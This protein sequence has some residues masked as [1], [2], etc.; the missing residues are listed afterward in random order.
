MQNLD[1]KLIAWF[2]RSELQSKN[3]GPNLFWHAASSTNPF[4]KLRV[5]AW[6]LEVLFATVLGETAEFYEQLNQRVLPGEAQR[7]MKRADF[8]AVNVKRHELPLLTRADA[9]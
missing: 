1:E 3:W 6:E 5:D 2:K 4:G 9:N 7:T 8:I